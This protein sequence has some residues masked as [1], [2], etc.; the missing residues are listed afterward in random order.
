MSVKRVWRARAAEFRK[1]DRD[2]WLALLVLAASLVVGGIIVAIFGH[3]AAYDD[4]QPAP[5]S[6]LRGTYPH[7]L[8]R[9]PR[10]TLVDVPAAAD[11]AL[12]ASA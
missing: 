6:R 1:L 3:Y 7:L 4:L 11:F 8:R 5:A 12:S 9:L 2:H 10:H